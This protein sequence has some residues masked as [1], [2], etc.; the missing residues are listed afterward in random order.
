M[1]LIQDVQEICCGNLDQSAILFSLIIDDK[2]PEIIESD[3]MKVK[4]VLLNLLSNAVKFTSAG[5]IDM[6][7]SLRQENDTEFIV[8]KVKDTGIGIKTEEMTRLFEA[9]TQADSSKTRAF[10]GTGLG[11]NI[12]LTY[13]DLL[14]GDISVTSELGEGSEFT[15]AFILKRNRE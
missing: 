5:S 8:V 9:F 15:F 10:G 3:E 12:A 4:Q 2:V 1:N 6:K 11:L 7:V 13:A 14:G